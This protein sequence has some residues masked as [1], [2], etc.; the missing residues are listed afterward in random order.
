MENEVCFPPTRINQRVK[1]RNYSHHTFFSSPDSVLLVSQFRWPF[2][3]VYPFFHPINWSHSLGRSRTKLVLS[4]NW[5]RIPKCSRTRWLTSLARHPC[6]PFTLLL[7]IF[8][9]LL[10]NRGSGSG[11]IRM[12][13]WFHPPSVSDHFLSLYLDCDRLCFDWL[14]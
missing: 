9:R 6:V 8:S 7:W 11:C 10:A 12:T 2:S 1:T 5:R 14:L 4:Q 13:R 3:S